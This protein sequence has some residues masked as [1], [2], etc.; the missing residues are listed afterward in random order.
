M[1]EDEVMHGIEDIVVNVVENIISGKGMKYDVPNRSSSNQLY[2]PELD[3][4]CLK[5]KVQTLLL[6]NNFYNDL[7]RNLRQ[8]RGCSLQHLLF[9]R[10]QLL[11]V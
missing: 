7:C 8:L 11:H 4:I 1:S 10:L 6:N 9:A 5:Q 3:R 2:V